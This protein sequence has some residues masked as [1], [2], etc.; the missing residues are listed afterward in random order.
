MSTKQLNQ[1][2][3]WKRFTTNAIDSPTGHRSGSAYIYD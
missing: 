2:W 3:L 1:P